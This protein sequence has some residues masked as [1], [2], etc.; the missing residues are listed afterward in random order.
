MEG[1]LA[2]TGASGVIYGIKLL[3][4]IGGNVH[5]IISESAKKIISDETNY[6]IDTLSKY[7]YKVYKNNE[8]EAAIAS[9]SYLF[10]YMIICPATISTISKITTGIQDNLITRAAAVSLKEKRKLIIVP[11]ET[12]LTSINLRSLATLS[13]EGAIILPAMPAFYHN[14]K[15]IDDIIN[16]VVGRILDQVNVKNNLFKR[17]GT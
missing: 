14:P 7:A 4:N 15:N 1:I 6:E 16:F 5:L 2:I 17:W 9:G 3:E 10:D 11:R 8:M 12:P 13:E